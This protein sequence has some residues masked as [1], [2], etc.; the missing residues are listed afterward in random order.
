MVEEVSDSIL[1][2]TFNTLPVNLELK[3]FDKKI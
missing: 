2:E 1:T 3:N